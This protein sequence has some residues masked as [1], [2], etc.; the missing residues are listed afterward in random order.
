MTT[1]RSTPDDG[2]GSST[3][4]TE[5]VPGVSVED[6]VM[7]TV[8]WDAALGSPPELQPYGG[9]IVGVP[10]F[11]IPLPVRGK[12]FGVRGYSRQVPHESG[13][14]WEW[15]LQGD[16]DPVDQFVD[17]LV[18]SLPGGIPWRV[19]TAREAVKL[20]IQ[21]MFSAGLPRATIASQVPAFFQAVAAEVA[22]RNPAPLLST[23][24]DK[25]DEE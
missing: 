17:S 3:D 11:S 6:L 18:S 12:L 16:T 5:A 4:P 19:A 9:A 23:R 21:R 2:S 25:H 22:A 24:E 14:R 20:M 10:P 8:V 1:P 15:V 13:T 7:V